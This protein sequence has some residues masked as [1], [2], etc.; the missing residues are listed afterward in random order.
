MGKTADDSKELKKPPE[1]VQ[2]V[3]QTETEASARMKETDGKTGSVPTKATEAATEIKK[4][5]CWRNWECI[6]KKNRVYNRVEKT[7]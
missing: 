4:K 3:S 6:D 7:S 2:N 5:I 1:E